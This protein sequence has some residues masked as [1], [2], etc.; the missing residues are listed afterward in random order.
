MSATNES[1]DLLLEEKR[2]EQK[3]SSRKKNTAV[4]VTGLPSDVTLDELEVHFSKVGI[5]MQ[6]MINGGPR[7]KIY[8]NE[9]EEPTG[10][11]L[12]V[13]LRE[14]SVGLACEILDESLLRPGVVLRV[15]QAQEKKEDAGGDEKG[16]KIEKQVWV[17]KMKEMKRQL[18]WDEDE[19]GRA[20][21]VTKN[22]RRKTE[23]KR[24]T[25]K[26]II[27]IRGMLQDGDSV[28]EIQSD[29]EHEIKRKVGPV[30]VTILEQY[31]LACCKFRSEEE[32]Q[33]CIALLNGRKYDGRSIKAEFYDGS[34]A[35]D[36]SNERLER[37]GNWL[38]E[39]S[40]D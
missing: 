29:L 16:G 17:E 22:V 25:S 34:F 35:I 4:Y 18:E 13:Y 37:F 40:E 3:Q 36:D 8:A 2:E 31:Q 5:I 21:L 39:Q 19:I 38:E 15:Q 27:V 33:R 28:E 10:D 11:C 7:I 32:A 12:V 23:T 1:V 24:S 20:S 26:R 14:E 9:A 30:T 6:D